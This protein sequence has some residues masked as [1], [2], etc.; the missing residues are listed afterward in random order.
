M[1]DSII[2]D[3]RRPLS[4][5][6]PEEIK[7]VEELF[8]VVGERISE[9]AANKAVEEVFSLLGVD[10]KKVE[11]VEEFKEDLRFG[12]KLRKLADHGIYAVVAVIFG[13]IAWAI[14]DGI[15]LKLKR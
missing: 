12:R 8:Y 9:T 13:A 7:T 6:T 14:I 1:T 4:A 10:V 5:C 11:S 3:I 2:T 15:A